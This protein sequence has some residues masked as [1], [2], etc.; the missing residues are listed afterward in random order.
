MGDELGPFIGSQAV[1]SGRLNRYELRRFYR[2]IM[3]NVYLDKRVQPS[4]RQRIVAAHLWAQG[5]AVVSGLSASA[6]HGAE[7]IDEDEPVELIWANARPPNGVITRK[8]LLLDNEIQ[9]VKGLVVTT[10]ER[11]AFDLGRRGR[12]DEAV[13]RLDALARA[14]LSEDPGCRGNGGTSSAYPRPPTA[15]AGARPRGRRRGVTEGN[16]V[17]THVDSRWIPTTRDTDSCPQR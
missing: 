2:P 13:A 5:E 3:P 10:P 7:W 1:A 6:L 16:V 9:R 17:A 4:L 8:E 15:G 11:T 12:L 14:T